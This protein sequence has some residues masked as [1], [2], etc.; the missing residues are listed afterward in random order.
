MCRY[1][2]PICEKKEKWQQE[3]EGNW[4]NELHLLNLEGD[5]LGHSHADCGPQDTVS[6]DLPLGTVFYHSPKKPW[7][8]PKAQ[9]YN[10]STHH[11]LQQA[12]SLHNNYP[13]QTSFNRNIN[14]SRVLH[15][16]SNVNMTYNGGSIMNT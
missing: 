13:T 2:L 4:N 11:L 14:H 15:Q 8:A 12:S 1:T 7:S 16:K 10:H 9:S 3:I 6:T 5:T